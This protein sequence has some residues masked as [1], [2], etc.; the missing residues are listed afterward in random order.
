M[1][2]KACTNADCLRHAAA[3]KMAWNTSVHPCDD[4]Y[5]FVCGSW[6][7]EKSHRR[8]DDL[9]A[10][11]ERVA[12]TE[13]RSDRL[14]PGKARKFFLSCLNAAAD[15]HS[16]LDVLK[17]WA[18]SMGMIQPR[19]QSQVRAVNR[20]P[21]DL[22]LDLAINWRMG[23]LSLQ[24][25][26]HLGKS[27]WVLILKPVLGSWRALLDGEDF[28]FLVDQHVTL[29]DAQRPSSWLQWNETVA[30]IRA[31]TSGTIVRSASDEA[32]IIVSDLDDLTQ[33]L[34]KGMWL[35]FINA[36][37][38]PELTFNESDPV[39]VYDTPI[40]LNIGNVFKPRSLKT[41]SEVFSWLVLETYLDVIVTQYKAHDTVD[42]AWL[43]EHSCLSHTSSFLGLL[44]VQRHLHRKFPS[45]RRESVDSFLKHI[46]TTWALNVEHAPWIDN[47]SRRQALKKVQALKTVLWPADEFFDGESSEALYDTFPDMDK[48]FAANLIETALALRRLVN[49][50]HYVDVYTKQMAVESDIVAYKYHLNEIHIALAAL[51]P[52][53]YYDVE[54][55]AMTYGGLGSLYAKEVSKIYDSTGRSLDAN[56]E[57]RV[58]PFNEELPEYKE[59]LR[60]NVTS[61]L[62]SYE[63]FAPVSGL[64]TAFESYNVAVSRDSRNYDYRLETLV[65]YSSDQVFFMTYCHI[66]CAPRTDYAAEEY[67]NIPL[68]NF[69]PFAEAF[70]CPLGSYMNPETKCTLFA[71]EKGHDVKYPWRRSDSIL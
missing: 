6:V 56:G 17:M 44:S 23:P 14:A 43:T 58:A 13:L 69:Q 4:F 10:E 7:A 66:L 65:E 16:N 48:P 8:M 27:Q 63:Y 26:V 36:H 70:D 53:V 31:A 59:K 71:A 38:T 68:G 28:M 25:T 32:A 57:L 29:L 1:P 37:F 61:N 34:P 30:A 51:N 64:E 21:L 50:S 18:S 3:I 9:A 33:W 35:E 42:K 49:H 41:L 55:F 22:L 15:V 20:H 2:V 19:N 62:P 24:A 47:D 67:C 39:V 40:M 45:W 5:A 12:L 46:R 52:P 60:C 11:A 54:M